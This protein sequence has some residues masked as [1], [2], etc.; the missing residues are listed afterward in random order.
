[1]VLGGILMKQL[2]LGSRFHLH[3]GLWPKIMSSESKSLA[4]ISA[5]MAENKRKLDLEVEKLQ[6]MVVEAKTKKIKKQTN[7]AK[8]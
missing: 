3:S 2:R 5:Y 4:Q 1:M 6:N 8:Q 7:M